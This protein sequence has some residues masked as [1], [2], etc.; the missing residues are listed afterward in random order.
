MPRTPATV[1]QAT[2][3]R[4]LRAARQAGAHAVE[5]RP[6]GTVMILLQAPPIVPAEAPADAFTEWEREYESAKA[7]R[8]RDRV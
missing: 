5:V 6:D 1:T 2:V 4:T 8:R 3:A 7:A